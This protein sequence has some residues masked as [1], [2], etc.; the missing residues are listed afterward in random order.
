V[1]PPASPLLQGAAQ[2]VPPGPPATIG[3]PSPVRWAV[4]SIS[5]RIAEDIL[6]RGIGTRLKSALHCL[7][8]FKPIYGAHRRFKI[9][10]LSSDT[11]MA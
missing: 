8:G 10:L 11:C 6:S 4:M 2:R 9:K 3:G 7:T 5:Y 1:I